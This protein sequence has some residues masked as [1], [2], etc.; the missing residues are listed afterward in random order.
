[1]LAAGRPDQAIARALV[2]TLDTVKCMWAMSW[3]SS[4][5]QV[6]PSPWPGSA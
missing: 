2:V 6:A 3:A 5:R 1:M 4:A